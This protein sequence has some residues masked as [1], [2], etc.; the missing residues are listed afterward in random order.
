MGKQ[1]LQQ[2][3]F[4]YIHTSLCDRINQNYDKETLTCEN[5]FYVGKLLCTQHLNTAFGGTI[6]QFIGGSFNFCLEAGNSDDRVTDL[7]M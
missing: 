2:D 4:Y 7:D 5:K 3:L 6:P 1:Y